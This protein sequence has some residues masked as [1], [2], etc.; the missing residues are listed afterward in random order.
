MEDERLRVEEVYQE[1]KKLRASNTQ[2]SQE[3]TKLK[4]LNSDHE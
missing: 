3:V 2:L 1:R 4:E